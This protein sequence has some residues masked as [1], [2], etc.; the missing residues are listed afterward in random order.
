MA[1]IYLDHA[2]TTIPEEKV[3]QAMADCMRQVWANPSATYGAAGEARRVMRLTRRCIA[4]MLGCDHTEIIFTSGG[5]ES[6]NLVLRSAAGKHVVM[7]AI[8]HS[9]LL[10][11]AK[12][13]DCDVTLVQPDRH[14]VIQPD[15]VEAALRP[16]TALIALQWANNETG[17][18]Q[19]V[20]ETG[21]MARKRR[22]PFHVD[23]VQAF[24]HV[25]VDAGCCDTLSL[26]AHK[27]Y[28]PRGTGAL[29]VRQGTKLQPLCAGGG[30]EMNLRS[31][32]ENVAGICGMELAAGLAAKDM[33]ERITRETMLLDELTQR[34]RRRIPSLVRLGEETARLPGVTALMLPGLSS[35]IAIAQLDMRGILVSGGAA[36]AASSGKPSHV[37]QAMGLSEKESRQ[38][39]RVSIGRHTTA[40]EIA[41]A[42]ETMVQV[43]EQYRG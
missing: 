2:A 16:D 8:E 36:C 32:T 26:S 20:A 38:V 19:P 14:G 10:D 21:R 12:S 1:V 37:Y 25:A 17:V 18:I 34:L 7:S 33:Q 24:G 28:G 15:A 22:I 35:E 30:Q 42:A 41:F 9:S 13:W 43:W 3:V 31:G 39:I 4:G 5:T 27:F 29:Y 11:A 6:N 23:A 40:E